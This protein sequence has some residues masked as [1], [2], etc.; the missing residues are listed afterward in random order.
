MADEPEII[1][2][3]NVLKNKVSFGPDGV[4]LEALERAEA[5][6]ANLQGNYLEWVQEDLQRLQ[7]LYETAIKLP[8]AERAPVMKQIFGIAH[9]VK[10]QGGSFGYG[11]V[12]AIGNQ[13]CRF[14]EGRESFTN[15]ELE[16]VRLHIDTIRMVIAKRMEGDGGREGESLMRGLQLVVNKVTK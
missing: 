4:D 2:V 12:T 14:L 16:A 10:G 8:E 11:L 1:Q 13:L 9:D 6:I 5:V 15:P 7:A 3:P